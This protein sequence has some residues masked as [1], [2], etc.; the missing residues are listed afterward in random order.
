LARRKGAK[1][2]IGRNNFDD[3]KEELKRSL[4]LLEELN[5]KPNEMLVLPKK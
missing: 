3:H 5:V 4:D 1:L 2:T